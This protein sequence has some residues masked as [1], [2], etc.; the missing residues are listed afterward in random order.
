MRA[1][2]FHR[3]KSITF[4]QGIFSEPAVSAEIE[5]KAFTQ[6]PIDICLHF[7]KE[8]SES[9]HIPQG[10]R[11]ITLMAFYQGIFWKPTLFTE[12]EQKVYTQLP[13]D[14]CCI[15]SRNLLS[16]RTFHRNRSITFHW[17]IFWEPAVSTEIEKKTFTTLCI[18]IYLHFIKESSENPHFP[19]R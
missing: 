10:Y 3:D 16:T 12:I 19:Q 4:H 17:G 7:I 5:Q 14:I 13:T 18:D 11:S 6:R 8:S 9:P 2:T 15:L 1:R